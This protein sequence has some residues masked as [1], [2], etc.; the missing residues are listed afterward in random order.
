MPVVVG[1]RVIGV[2]LLSRTPESI[3]EALYGKRWH[4]LGLLA[5][6][7]ATVAAFAFIGVTMIA[8]PLRAVAVQAHRAAHGERAVLH[9]TAGPMVREVAELW[10][11]LTRMAESMEQRTD[12]I[13][14]FAAHVSHA[15]KT[16]L[17]TIR[18]TVELLREHLSEMSDGQRNQFLANLDTEAGRMTL[19]VSRLLDL[20]RADVMY[21]QE[22]ESARP[23]DVLNRLVERYRETG[24]HLYL[25]I[26]ADASV[27][28]AE[29]ALET[30]LINL[31]DNALQHAGTEADVTV[32]LRS[33]A[34][35]AVMTIA[36]NGPGIAPGNFDRI[37]EPFFSLTRNQGGTGLGLSIV[38]SL[39]IAYRG[40]VEAVPSDSGAVFKIEL[41]LAK[42][43]QPTSPA[44]TAANNANPPP[45]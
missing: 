45:P 20:A 6:L 42:A 39:A 11:T 22:D 29:E 34:G 1:D 14:E 19:L 31:L 5:L 23:S 30:I 37:F 9:P 2:I 10:Q 36:D 35:I 18:G 40:S 17:T 43:D 32:I 4:L 44:R 21:A 24:M 38:R 28:I 16:P 8:R 15:L 33:E 12:Y 13:R 26:P 3:A 25:N 41:P 27:A 7:L